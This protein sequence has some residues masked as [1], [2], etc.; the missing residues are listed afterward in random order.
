MSDYQS[1]RAARRA[2]LVVTGLRWFPV[3]LLIPIVVLYMTD[4]GLSLA[5]V[6]LAWAVQGVLVM[7]LELPTGGLADALGRRP[8]LILA[9]VVQLASTAVFLLAQSLAAFIVALGIQ[10]VFRAL[11]SG[12]LEAWYVDRAT[13]T[14]PDRR[15]E[16][17][18]SAAAV[19]VYVSVAVASLLAGLVGRISDLPFDPLTSI[20]MLSF[21]LQIVA[22]LGVL[23]LVRETRPASGWTSAKAA[24]ADAPNVVRSAL[25]LAWGKRSLRLILGVELFWGA[26]LVAVELLWQPRTVEILGS[27]DDPFVFGVM[28]AGAWAAGAVGA[29]L[30]GP[31]L[32]LTRGSTPWAAAILRLVQGAT[33]LG[34]AA[35]G[36][37]IGL[38]T[39]FVAFYLV[40][41]TANPAHF[42]LLHRQTTKEHRTT[43]LSANSLV[44][45]GSGLV[46]N[47]GLGA[48][49]TSAGIRPAL[50]VGGLLLAAAAPLYLMAGDEPRQGDLPA[51]SGGPG[52]AVSGDHTGA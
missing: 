19:V 31:L 11:D 50:V 10:G 35:V 17:D 46:A 43:M 36:G 37:L 25:R 52:G 41:G 33:V 51:A 16:G 8:V 48:L 49:A 12:P 4:R 1:I 15:L 9:S 6:G 27:A 3:G 44:A 38:I 18:L 42:A 28:G 23:L 29:A 47:I 5:G 13:A 7:L 20:V 32:K 30:L 34:M 22:L 21:L 24:A 40:H 39:A 26:G 45:Q 2:F 14:D